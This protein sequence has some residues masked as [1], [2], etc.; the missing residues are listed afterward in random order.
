MFLYATGRFPSQQQVSP[1]QI[2]VEIT[3]EAMFRQVGQ[4]YGLDW[5]ILVCQA[6]YESGFDPL[7]IGVGQDT[8]L[9]QIVPGTWDEWAPR[10]G[11]TDP[12]DPYSN[13]LVGAAYLAF[14]RD[15]FS[16]RGYTDER[17][18]LVAYNWGPYNL[19]Q[20]L[21][22]GGQWTDVPK[23]RRRYAL[24]ILRA[25]EELPVAWEAIRKESV[26]VILPVP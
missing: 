21:E 4:K 13:V 5:R 8:G 3:Y 16:E 25:R 22:D 10:I 2:P 11:V 15:Y 19:Q 17:W 6:Y 7:V 23:I 12:H 26:A 1:P 18:M 24:N 20:F 14:L 9:M